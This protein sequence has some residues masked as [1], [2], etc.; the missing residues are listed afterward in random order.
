MRRFL[1]I[2]GIVIFVSSVSEAQKR[3]VR[4]PAAAEPPAIVPVKE[5]VDKGSVSGRTYTNEK[6]NFSIT[7]PDT[8]LVP[9][10]DFEEYMKKQGFDLSLK[11][12]DNLGMADRAKV[13]QSLKRVE[14]LVTAYRSMPGSNDNAIMRVSAEDLKPNPQIKDAVDYCDAIRNSYKTMKLPADLKYS[15][16]GAERLGPH[17]FAYLDVSSKAGKKRM[18]ATVR[19]GFAI[20]FTLSYIS[21]EDLQ[22]MRQILSEGNFRL[23]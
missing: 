9:D 20:L 4:K 22:T 21:D 15:E 8:W 3:T 18:Y 10:S 1:S 23:K 11:A 16:T 2:L 13:N 12:P 14:I 17:Q 6:L 5:I 19:N 7:F